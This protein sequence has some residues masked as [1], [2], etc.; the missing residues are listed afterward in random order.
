MSIIDWEL[1]H[2][3]NN[4]DTKICT[5]YFFEMEKTFDALI[6]SLTDSEWEKIKLKVETR[7]AHI[8]ADRLRVKRESAIRFGDWILKHTVYPGQ[9]ENMSECWFTR[10]GEE[11]TYYTSEEL[12]NIYVRGDWDDLEDDGQ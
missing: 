3:I 11:I 10:F 1:W 4:K 5:K 2:K 12:F 7:R 9:D 6:E 8:A